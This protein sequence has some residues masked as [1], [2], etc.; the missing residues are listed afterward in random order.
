MRH[1]LKVVPTAQRH[2]RQANRWWRENR[3][4]ASELFV[5]ELENAFDV[6]TAQ[7][8]IAPLAPTKT[9]GIRRFHLSRVHYH[10]YYR[11]VGDE[12]EVLAVWHTSRESPPVL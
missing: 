9:P 10:L 7:P 4:A 11:A 5:D 12:V 6:I 2:I 3:T 1:R 8:A